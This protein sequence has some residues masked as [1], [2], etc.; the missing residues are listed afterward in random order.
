VWLYQIEKTIRC[1]YG[2]P[3]SY[4]NIWDDLPYPMWNAPY[5]ESCD[6]LLSISKQTYNLN[7]WVLSP[8]KCRTIG[9]T[10]DSEGNEIKDNFNVTK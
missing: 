5:Y 9:G 8:E 1:D 2:I 4:I 7:K 6:L 10:F 3:I